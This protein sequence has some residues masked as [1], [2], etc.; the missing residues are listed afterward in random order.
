MARPSNTHTRRA[1]IVDGLIE[2]MATR[3]YDGAS[4]ADIARAAGLAP[5]L[6]HYHFESKLE[7]LV[8]AVRSLAA[9]H[10]RALE[11]ALANDASP[12]AQLATLVEVHLGTGAHVAPAALATWVL[13][14]AEAL[15]EPRVQAE[16][17]LALG[18]LVTRAADIIRRGHTAGLLD[19]A[20]PAAAAAA[21]IATIQ[22]YF[23]VA[24]TARAL[25][26]AGSAVTCTLRMLD[27]LVR[28]R[29]S[30]AR[31]AAR[32]PVAARTHA[33]AP[34]KPRRRAR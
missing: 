34:A 6:V 28:P 9:R 7:I 5:G 31:P 2:V 29:T 33:A 13:A 1:Q 22:G 24:A 30:L 14:G 19:C 25:I 18:A 16:V 4:T 8:E 15:R 32:R 21:L 3:G 20:D 10:T 11:A 17:A 12:S 27:G 23:T 26:P